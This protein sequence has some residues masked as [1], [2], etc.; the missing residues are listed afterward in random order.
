LSLHPP[1]TLSLAPRPGGAQDRAARPALC[2]V[3]HA[4]RHR[5]V[6][7][8]VAADDL[9]A[10]RGRGAQLEWLEPAL[11]HDVATHLPRTRRAARADLV[12]AVLAVNDERV[13]DAEL[14]EDAGDL[15]PERRRRDA[16]QH[17]PHPGGIR[18]RSEDVEDRAA[19]D[20]S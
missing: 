18:E 12:E 16:E 13:L 17:A 15:L 2:T 14:G 11:T 10:A 9:R 3:Q 8:G 20:L 7:R 1:A 5:R 4:P 19:P 6:L